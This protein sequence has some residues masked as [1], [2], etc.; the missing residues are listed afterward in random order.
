[1]DTLFSEGFILG[2]EVKLKTCFFGRPG[3]HHVGAIWKH[4]DMPDLAFSE[5]PPGDYPY[6]TPPGVPTKPDG[7]TLYYGFDQYV[8]LYSDQPRRGWGLFGRASISDGNP[9]PYRFFLSAGIGGDSRFRCDRG[10]TFGAGWFYKG[11][12]NEFGPIP[13]AALGPRDGTGVE[14]YYNF[15]VTPWLNVTSDVQYLRPDLNAF[16]NDSLLYGLRVNM[17]L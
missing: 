13:F 3:Q 2:S 15:Q 5:P 4:H 17:R 8:K 6:P 12:S 10:D 1:M 16:G 11:T 9:T 14:L 7:Y